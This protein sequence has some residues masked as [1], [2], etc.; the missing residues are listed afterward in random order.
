MDGAVDSLVD[1]VRTT[2]N[3]NSEDRESVEDFLAGITLD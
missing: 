2:A 1:L 3:S